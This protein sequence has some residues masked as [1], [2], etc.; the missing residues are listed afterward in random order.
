MELLLCSDGPPDTAIIAAGTKI[1][2][3]IDINTGLIYNQHATEHRYDSVPSNQFLHS[4]A[5]GTTTGKIP[6]VPV[7]MSSMSS[8]VKST[9]D[10]ITAAGEDSA[11]Y[12]AASDF[13]T[14]STV[15]TAITR[16]V[17]EVNLGS[18]P[19]LSGSFTINGSGFTPEKV[20]TIQQAPGPYTNKGTLAD[21]AEMDGVTVSAYCEDSSTIRAYWVASGPVVGN[22]KFSYRA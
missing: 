16:V 21:E 11:A 9:I 13:A 5:L 22:M 10:G 20:V 18:V 1:S 7:P 4:S 15:T 19:S 12:H 3:C 17:T 2:P 14:P 6:T 8:P